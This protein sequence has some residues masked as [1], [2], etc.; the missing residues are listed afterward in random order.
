MAPGVRLETRQSGKCEVIAIDSTKAYASVQRKVTV[1]F[2]V[3][4]AFLI[5]IAVVAYRN[6]H[7]Y[8]ETNGWVA[9]SYQ[10]LAKL[11]VIVSR[12][13][14]AGR[15]ERA[16]LITMTNH[17]LQWRIACSR[18]SANDVAIRS[19]AAF[20]DLEKK[21]ASR[22]HGGTRRLRRKASGRGAKDPDG[23]GWWR[24]MASRRPATMEAEGG[25]C[26]AAHRASET[27]CQH[28]GNFRSAGLVVF[29][30]LVAAQV[31]A[32]P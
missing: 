21:V 19:A 28:C 4:I 5:V 30:F 1:G 27:G 18:K 3:A 14:E 7:G 13:N 31:I 17:Y 26:S 10:V 12:L 9:H 25:A 24:W 32:V 15:N 22:N 20:P 29:L 11:S 16:Y 23:V 2:G 6:A 8:V